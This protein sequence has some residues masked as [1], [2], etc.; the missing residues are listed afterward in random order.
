MGYSIGASEPQAK[1]PGAR[2]QRHSRNRGLWEGT[3]TK[4]EIKSTMNTFCRARRSRIGRRV[5]SV[6]F[7]AYNV[8]GVTKAKSLGIPTHVP[9]TG[10]SGKN[11]I[12]CRRAGLNTHAIGLNQNT[13]IAT[14]GTKVRNIG[15]GEAYTCRK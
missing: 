4:P 7:H 12:G 9:G 13:R 6:A 8:S 10:I 11:T 3:T 2:E 1:P 15:N 5:K 14:E